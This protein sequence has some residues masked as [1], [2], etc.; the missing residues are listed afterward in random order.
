M[1]LDNVAHRARLVV[2]RATCTNVN[3]L[4]DSDLHV[5][6]VFPVPQR[7]ENGVGKAEDEDILDGLFAQIVIDAVNLIFLENP[8]QITVEFAGGVQVL[9]EGFFDDDPGIAVAFVQPS[10]TSEYRSGGI[11]R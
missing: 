2:V 10:A 4:G 11:A 7:L 3:G 8:A 9:A 5:V 6:D 1:V